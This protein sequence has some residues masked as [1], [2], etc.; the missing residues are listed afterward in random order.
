MK[1]N[2]VQLLAHLMRRA[3]FGATRDQLDTLASDG[4]EATVEKLLDTKAPS[5]VHEDIIRRYLPDAAG[6]LGGDG[7]SDYWLYRMVNSHN[8][9]QEKMA[10]FWHG[11][12]C[13][14]YDKLAQGL[15]LMDQI[16]MFRQYGTGDLPT[17]LVELSKDPSM[18]LYLD[19]HENHKTAINENYGRELLE[20][21]SMGIGNY[22]EDDIKECARAFTGWT[23]ANTE[24]MTIRARN[25]SLW[26]YGRLNLQFEYR[27]SDHDHDKK[28]FLGEHGRFNGTDIIDIICK[29]PATGKFIARHMYN[30]FVS[31]EPPVSQWPY[32]PPSN[33]EAIN[34]LSNAYLDSGYNISAM[35]RVLF[36][37]DFFKSKNCWYAKVKS[38]AELVTNVLRLTKEFEE[39]DPRLHDAAMDMW[40]MGQNLVLP[41]SVEGWHTGTEWIDSGNF[42]ERINFSTKRFGDSQGTGVTEMISR[43]K[44]NCGEDFTSTDLV[45]ECLD[46]LGSLEVSEKSYEVLIEHASQIISLATEANSPKWEVREMLRFIA[47]IPE[48]QRT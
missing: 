32:I 25:D 47:A 48:F 38:P 24:Y 30:F 22:S 15:V 3:G 4:Y 17:L 13:T 29:Q 14:G 35:L 26:P 44:M 27:S 6:L 45:N 11:V 12:L 40:N 43:F 46:V 31:D 9:L 39:P 20:L 33:P 19:N 18:I 36:H 7:F 42:V 1:S 23:I 41:P 16:D 28:S 10:L 5:E 2:N 37:S 34:T 8:Q 21:F